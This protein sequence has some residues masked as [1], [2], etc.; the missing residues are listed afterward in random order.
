MVGLKQTSSKLW[1]TLTKNAVD[2][3]NVYRFTGDKPT[4]CYYRHNQRLWHW[5]PQTTNC[6]KLEEYSGEVF[7]YAYFIIMFSGVCFWPLSETRHCRGLVLIWA[8]LAVLPLRDERC[9]RIRPILPVWKHKGF[10][11][12]DESC[13]LSLVPAW[14][15][16]RLCWSECWTKFH[17]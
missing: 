12:L 1:K 2:A 11:M 4:E 9:G 6:W 10:W 15:T 13:R 17:L 5:D 3:K 8:D 7:L 14:D 16:F